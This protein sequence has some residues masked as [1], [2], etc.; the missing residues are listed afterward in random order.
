[1]ICVERK[2][3]EC[4][5]R[6]VFLISAGL[7]L[8]HVLYNTMSSCNNADIC[9]SV[10]L[11]ILDFPNVTLNGSTEP[12]LMSN[13]PR[14]RKKHHSLW[15]SIHTHNGAPCAAPPHAHTGQPCHVP[16]M[17]RVLSTGLPRARL[18]TGGPEPV[19]VVL[20]LCPLSRADSTASTAAAQAMNVRKAFHRPL[21]G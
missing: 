18:C 11:V 14:N 8:R 10:V 7:F 4:T 6:N 13:Q 17:A 20:P 19:H 1:M 12:A 2:R 5:Y 16:S 9:F 3:Q 21:V 15:L